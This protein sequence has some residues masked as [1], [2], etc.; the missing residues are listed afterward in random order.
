MAPPQG[1]LPP[2]N[3]WITPPL[4]QEIGMVGLRLDKAV[5]DVK[6][7]EYSSVLYTE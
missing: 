5:S 3:L 7:L 2:L 6:Y 1:G 4:H